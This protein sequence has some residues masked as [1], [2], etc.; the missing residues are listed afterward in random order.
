MN[1]LNQVRT[2]YETNYKAILDTIDAMGGDDHIKFHR[3]RRSQLFA[4]LKEL[5]KREHYLD[6]LENRMMTRQIGLH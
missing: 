4:K 2:A 6:E 1:N 3:K 5:Q